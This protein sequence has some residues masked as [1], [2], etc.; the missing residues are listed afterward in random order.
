MLESFRYGTLRIVKDTEIDH[1]FDRL[2]DALMFGDEWYSIYVLADGE[3]V[4]VFVGNTDTIVDII[5]C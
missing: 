3:L 2:L 4:A 5:V 1:L